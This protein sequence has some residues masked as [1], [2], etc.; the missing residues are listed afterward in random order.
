MNAM[1]RRLALFAAML[2]VV[3]ACGPQ[4]LP[5]A[6]TSIP[7]LA[8]ATMPAYTA[9]PQPTQPPSAGETAAPAATVDLVQAGSQ[10]Y[11]QNCAICHSLT[12]ESKVGPGLA[13]LFSLSNLPNGQP[14]NEDNLKSWIN[15]GG[16]GM[17]GFSFSDEQMT[18]LVAFLKNATQ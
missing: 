8:P 18:E 13:G 7:T 10:I 14:F 3:A 5:N 11:D 9:A 16:G 12:A 17:P 2:A 1:R 15:T 6:P 4:P